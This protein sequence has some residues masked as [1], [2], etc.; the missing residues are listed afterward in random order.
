MAKELE[1][2]IKAKDWKTLD[3]LCQKSPSQ[4]AA[5]KLAELEEQAQSKD[6]QKGIRKALFTLKQKGFEPKMATAPKAE[7][8]VAETFRKGLI[9]TSDESGES[10][11]SFGVQEGQRVRWLFA[12]VHPRFGIRAAREKSMPLEEAE[13]IW[14]GMRV[15]A[16]RPRIVAEIDA[17]YALGRLKQALELPTK[18]PV[19][20]VLATWRK[21]LDPAVAVK[22]HPSKGWKSEEEISQD[23]RR[24]IPFQLEPSQ[25]WRLDLGAAAPILQELDEVQKKKG[26]AEEPERL[27]R[28]DAAQEKFQAQIMT[29]EL[30]NDHLT[31]LRDLALILKVRESKA[32]NIAISAAD[33]LEKRGAASDYAY[34]L[35]RKTFLMFLHSLSQADQQATEQEAAPV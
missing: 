20:P 27:K 25:P 4:A 9:L 28:L 22:D 2:S 5:D 13:A 35:I 16:N 34:G 11:I 12:N 21:H 17:D 33:D 31:R 10:T 1:A 30:V 14:P 6:E 29:P 3:D 15:S 18:A 23:Y 32:W 8:K 7:A 24:A 19:P 26:T